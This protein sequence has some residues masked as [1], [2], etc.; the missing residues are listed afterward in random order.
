MKNSNHTFTEELKDASWYDWWIVPDDGVLKGFCFPEISSFFVDINYDP[1]VTLLEP[2]NYSSLP[3]N[4]TAI[5]LSFLAEDRDGDQLDIEVYLANTTMNG[6]DQWKTVYRQLNASEDQIH[7]QIPDADISAGERYFWK[8]SIVDENESR[9]LSPVFTFSLDI[10]PKN[11][12][13][14]ANPLENRTVVAG[15]FFSVLAEAPYD[16][17]GGELYYEWW[18]FNVTGKIDP[19]NA[20]FTYLVANCEFTRS[21]SP[22]FLSSLSSPGTYLILLNLSDGGA[23]LDPPLLIRLKALIH[24]IENITPDPVTGGISVTGVVGTKIPFKCLAGLEWGND[25][26]V[27][28]TWIVTMEDNSVVYHSSELLLNFTKAADYRLE[29]VILTARGLRYEFSRNITAV[30]WEDWDAA[31]TIAI[32][33]AGP[34]KVN[35]NVS[36]SLNTPTYLDEVPR[37]KWYAVHSDNK[38]HNITGANGTVWTFIPGSAGVYTVTVD[39]ELT[40]LHF[41]LELSLQVNG[42]NTTENGMENEGANDRAALKIDILILIF[43]VG[44]ILAGLTW[45]VVI[46]RKLR[47]KEK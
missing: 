6:Q 20:T 42:T 1:T 15:E 4:A 25:P 24:V 18:L 36:F 40:G 37:V 23:Y 8:V 39:I 32:T 27:N 43:I 47:K 7:V 19:Y 21:A 29:L 3:W 31:W 22:T 2:E 45:A 14:T 44:I 33:S 34:V 30:A 28:Y 46:R 10:A 9:A 26:P 13:P 5:T 16:P 17:E 11:Q 38:K 35:E 41:R 12:A